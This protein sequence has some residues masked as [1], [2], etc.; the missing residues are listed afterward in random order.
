MANQSKNFVFSERST[1]HGSLGRHGAAVVRTG[2]MGSTLTVGVTVGRHTSGLVGLGAAVD[3]IQHVFNVRESLEG[4]AIF[5]NS[6]SSTST[7]G[8]VATCTRAVVFDAE[9]N[10][11]TGFSL[12]GLQTPDIHE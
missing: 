5:Q 9:G 1:S 3:P 11:T 8:A 10:R 12:L 6:T 4:L 7:V 2:V